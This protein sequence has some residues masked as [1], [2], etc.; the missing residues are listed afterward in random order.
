MFEESNAFDKINPKWQ[1]RLNRCVDI[2]RM[3]ANKSPDKIEIIFEQLKESI[4]AHT[5]SRLEAFIFV[6]TNICFVWPVY[7]PQLIR[8]F[9]FLID[10]ESNE[11][12][13]GKTKYLIYKQLFH[14]YFSDASDEVYVFI[15][16]IFLQCLET[17]ILELDEFISKI[18]KRFVQKS[19]F[20]NQLCILGL[21]FSPEIEHNDPSF[22]N[23][24]RD[25]IEQCQ[26]QHFLSSKTYFILCDYEK[27]QS[28]NWEYL[29]QIRKLIP[30][31]GFDTFKSIVNDDL[32]QFIEIMN[33]EK[34]TTP[35]SDSVL[36]N[37]LENPPLS[38]FSLIELEPPYINAAAISG[39]EKIFGYLYESGASLHS[40]CKNGAS[41]DQC[42]CINP[43]PAIISILEKENVN[44]DNALPSFSRC[45][46]IDAINEYMYLISK[47][48]SGVSRTGSTGINMSIMCCNFLL[49][50]ACLEKNS[51]PNLEDGFGMR[52]LDY[53]CQFG[54]VVFYKSLL[55]CGADVTQANTI[56]NASNYGNSHILLK[57]LK[58]DQI[59]PDYY[60][61]KKDM[62]AL[63]AAILNS[64]LGCI[65]ILINDGRINL[66]RRF[67]NNLTYINFAASQN[68]VR[69]FKFI[70]ERAEISLTDLHVS[71]LFNSI[72]FNCIQMTEFLLFGM[73]GID[74]N[75]LTNDQNVNALWLSVARGNYEMTEMILNNKVN[76]LSANEIV[77]AQ[78]SND[79]KMIDILSKYD[80]ELP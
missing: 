45:F 60:D 31:V 8:I 26:N 39:A 30:E 17:N 16:Q 72:F 22:F 74:P 20:H 80:V 48:K 63:K 47:A 7:I 41:I 12:I 52:P 53:A 49:F 40:T 34:A 69:I 4:Y 6:C 29:K 79:A 43:K 25:Y 38:L 10:S 62:T 75:K 19:T 14:W 36:N 61:Q 28:N 54:N 59:D 37:Y 50:R 32:A 73:E 64:H 3:I 68:D 56:F 51:D 27:Y 78:D 57:L 70:L 76:K 58:N 15:L 71:P 2:T 11:N 44:F 65:K 18:K 46:D 1:A 13:L 9:K 66:Q 23:Q 33:K 67:R 24:T 42:A 77:Q 21:Y 5:Q 55:M 35:N